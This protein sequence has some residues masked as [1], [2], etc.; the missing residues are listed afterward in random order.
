MLLKIRPIHIEEY[1]TVNLKTA[2]KIS[3]LVRGMFFSALDGRQLY[4]TRKEYY[5]VDTFYQDLT[6]IKELG[7]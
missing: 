1:I 3:N 7:V 6:A 4:L 5:A 2:L